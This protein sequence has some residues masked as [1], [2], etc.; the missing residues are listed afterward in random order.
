MLGAPL[1]KEVRA[2]ELLRRP[3][4]DYAAVTALSPVGESAEVTGFSDEL[5]EEVALQLDVQAKYAGYI[6]RQ[7]REID[8]HARQERL[9]LPADIDYSAV[10]G[11]STEARQRL[12]AARPGTLGQASRLEGVTPSTVSLLLIHLKKRELKQSA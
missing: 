9:R 7:Q 5:A 2:T 4:L 6:E 3:E 12:S 8:K 11:L 10:T 1:R